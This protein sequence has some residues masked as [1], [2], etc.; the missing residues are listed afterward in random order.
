[1]KKIDLIVGARP[2]FIKAF[3]VYEA[4]EKTGKFDLRLI[5]T[6][7]HYDDNMVDI[8]F[9]QLKMKN[10]D[11][12]LM[13]G[14]GSHSEQTGKVMIAIEKE[15]VKH[16][17]DLVI[18]FGDVNS[19]VAAALTATKLHILVAHVEAGLRSFD[20]FYAGRNKQSAY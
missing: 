17:P 15:F 6:S 3:P 20:R 18:V 16:R 1:M 7:Q 8:F 13:V 14:N 19:T 2:N 5:N 12:N 10:P 4:L 11:I 9:R